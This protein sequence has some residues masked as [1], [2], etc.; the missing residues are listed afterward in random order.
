[1]PVLEGEVPREPQTTR[2]E[3]RGRV[4]GRVACRLDDRLRHG[5]DDGQVSHDR[6][7]GGDKG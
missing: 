4:V 6:P 2:P 1:M 3:D 5:A 7:S